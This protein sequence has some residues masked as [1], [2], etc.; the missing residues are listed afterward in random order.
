MQKILYLGHFH[1][2]SSWGIAAEG[3]VK[4]LS[5]KY[6]V[7]CR[8]VKIRGNGQPSDYINEKEKISLDGVDTVIQHVL[9]EHMSYNSKYRCIGIAILES[10]STVYN[11]WKQRYD[12]MDEIWCPTEYHS[13]KY[14]WKYVPHAFDINRYN[15]KYESIL[16]NVNGKYLFYTVA[17]MNTRKRLTA[18]LRAFHTAFNINDN[19]GFVI[20]THQSGVSAL[21]TM[22]SLEDMNDKVKNEL[23]LYGKYKRFVDPLII[24]DKISEDNLM[25]IHQDCHTFLL[26]SYGE[27][28]CMPCFDALGF[29][30]YIIANDIPGVQ[31]YLKYANASLV[32]NQTTPCFGTQQYLLDLHSGREN[33]W[34][35]NMT[36]LIDQMRYAYE[37]KLGKT[38]VNKDLA[39]QFSYE[40]VSKLI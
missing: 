12:L 26:S 15:Q 28:F 18:L 36:E 13:N 17:E 25:S 31:D 2:N 14:R 24:A 3:Y 32:G 16:S 8:S 21:Q 40:S 6:D 4:S 38:E 39:K 9:P 23:N 35:I 7:V 10:D 20:K 29:G 27:G 5:L 19:V 37:N 1:E 22:K 11:G 30:N 34:E 33:W